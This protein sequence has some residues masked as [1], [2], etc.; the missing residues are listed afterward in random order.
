M[1]RPFRAVMDELMPRVSVV[2]SPYNRC[3]LLTVTLHAALAQREVGIEVIVVDDGRLT[4]PNRISAPGLASMLLRSAQ[5]WVRRWLVSD[6]VW[7][8]EAK[9]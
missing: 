7:V 5:G 6:R 4:A 8:R 1:V 2:M 9:G 3:E